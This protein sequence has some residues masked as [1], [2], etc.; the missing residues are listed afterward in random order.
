MTRRPS[1]DD[2]DQENLKWFHG[3]I[4]RQEAEAI[5]LK[6]KSHIVFTFLLCLYI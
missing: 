6:G 3:K 1:R 2:T 5:L 4:S